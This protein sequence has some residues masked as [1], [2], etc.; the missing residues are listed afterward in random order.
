[1]ARKTKEQIGIE[2]TR[3]ELAKEAEKEIEGVAPVEASRRNTDS[4]A[5]AKHWDSL[6]M[7]GRY[8]VLVEAGIEVNRDW[9]GTCVP[10]YTT[11]D[12]LLYDLAV[13]VTPI[14]KKRIRHLN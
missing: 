6:D 12:Q 14:L 2:T 8:A 3:A 5:H 7:D 13:K 10:E 1:M 9:W 4:W 11:F